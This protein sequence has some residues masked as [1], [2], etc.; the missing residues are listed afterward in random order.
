MA[1]LTKDPISGAYQVKQ[2]DNLSKIASSQGIT[3]ASLLA[4]NPQYAKNP[5]L[6]HPGDV[7]K[8]GAQEGPSYN[9]LTASQYTP[10]VTNT[11]PTTS[12]TEALIK[13]LKEAQARDSA[14]QGNLMKQSQDLTSMGIDDAR[15]NFN[16]PNLAP[17][18]GTSLGMSAQNEFDPQQLSIANQQKLATQNLGN[19][20]DMIEFTQDAYDKEQERAAR[21][22][23]KRLDAIEKA[24]D[25]A[26]SNAKSSASFD[27]DARIREFASDLQALKG[28]DG[29]IDP[30]KWMTARDL[31]QRLGGSDATF[32]SNFKRYLNPKSYKLAGYKDE[33]NGIDW[34]KL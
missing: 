1:T 10:V 15:D 8:F 5:N 28:Q 25:R 4:S 6:I 18:S 3:L 16:N 2:G 22:E 34:S 33:A 7:V 30:Y 24:K 27:N 12:F 17:S 23:E 26:A 21:A 13:M 11:N 32:E 20:T 19:V 9:S 31:W 14:G 29:Y